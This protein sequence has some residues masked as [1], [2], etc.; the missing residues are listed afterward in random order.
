MSEASKL[1]IQSL[2]TLVAEKRQLVQGLGMMN[3]NV[4]EATRMRQSMQFAQARSE[5]WNAEDALR[6]A[7]AAEEAKGKRSP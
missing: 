5:L 2:S 4:D 1:V 3:A 6:S 7:I